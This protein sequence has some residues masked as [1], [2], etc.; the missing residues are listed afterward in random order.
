[1]QANIKTLILTEKPSVA[2][3]FARALGCKRKDGYFEG[4]E[5]V[6]TW[7]FGH[8]FEISDENLPQKWELGNLPIFP[9]RFEYKLRSSQAGKQFR[10]IKELLA[11]AERVIVATDAGREGELIARLILQKA[12]LKDWSKVYRFWTSSALTPE[13]IRR[14]L[15][16]LKPAKEYDSLYW[17]ALARQH[18]DFVVGINLTRAVSLRSSGGVW[19]VG[20]V[21]TPTLALVVQRDL[22]IENF[23]PKPY[24]VIKALFSADGKTYEGV[25]IGKKNG[26]KVN[27]S[28]K[29]DEEEE[30]REE[31]EEA[32]G[33]FDYESVK[34]LVEKLSSVKQAVV[35]KVE[36]KK[37][38]EYP[39][40]LYSL[41]SLQ[42]DANKELG[43]SA[44]KTLEIAQKLYEERKA[45]SYPRS[46]AEYLSESSI[47]LVKEVL[48]RLKREDL[49]EKV[50]KV[51]KRV[52]DDRKLTDHHAIIPLRD[53]EEEWSK[54]EK[55]LFR[56]IKRRFLAAFYDPFIA[57]DTV[58][59]TQIAGEDF[60]SRGSIVLQL[61]YKELYG[62]PQDK[63]L[64]KLEKGQR[65]D[66]L[67]VWSEKRWTKPPPRYTEGALIKKMEKLSLGTPATRA[68]IIETLK[69]RGYL[70][71]NKKHL[72]STEKARQ[73]IKNLQGSKIVSVEMTSEWEQQ[74]ESIYKNKKG[75]GGYKDF[76]ER[77][78][79][80]TKEEV[81]KIKE[82]TFQAS[83]KPS[84]ENNKK[85]KKKSKKG[86]S[87]RNHPKGY[88]SS[89]R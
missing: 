62:K 32:G 67:K 11:K 36:K 28:K 14:E 71:L 26:G 42:R 15:R 58:V 82:M 69:S 4:G 47:P 64:P 56:L 1:M 54:D 12:G 68:S 86:G 48:K 9:E 29:E 5:Y 16:N 23:K 59:I 52:F 66:V 31:E 49:V 19:S 63:L 70:V 81:E 6:I 87:F 25:W 53:E 27:A 21:Q 80:F 8:L 43:F 74:L 13:V 65:V 84:K 76:L 75:F 37:R 38:V 83:I 10:V 34:K 78:K 60:Y 40:P 88:R 2:E 24:W 7:A 44:Q 45:I 57:L 18:A 85:F 55:A 46:D 41:S 3:D 17:C 20:R 51:G 72:I 22:E 73:L 39:P 33:V 50:E 79:A 30:E 35:S 61:G 77:I 89:G